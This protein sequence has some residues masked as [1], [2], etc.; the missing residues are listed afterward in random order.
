MPD[1]PAENAPNAPRKKARGKPPKNWREVFLKTLAETAVFASA[2][3]VAQVDPRT[4]RRHRRKDPDFAER[5]DEA[6]E[7]ALDLMELE[8]RR[9]ALHG[10]ERPVYQ[11]GKLVGTIREYSDT[12]MIFLLKAYRPE[13]FRERYEVRP[14][15]SGDD[16]PRADRDPGCRR[17]IQTGRSTLTDDRYG[18]DFCPILAGRARSGGEG[19][20]S[21]GGPLFR[22]P[23]PGQHPHPS[24]APSRQGGP[25]CSASP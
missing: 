20:I 8:A 10:T 9:R 12:L 11:G 17:P 1:D 19:A 14:T 2:C 25:P 13:R 23:L 5:W 15:P 3:K 22:G 21:P 7:L 4:A 24:R 16:H 18:D 6:L